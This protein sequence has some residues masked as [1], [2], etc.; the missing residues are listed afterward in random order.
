MDLSSQGKIEAAMAVLSPAQAVQLAR[1]VEMDRQR[2][3]SLPHDAILGALRP[4]LRLAVL[5]LDRLPTA[6]RLFCN[7]FE[8]LLS[9][10]PRESKMQGRIQRRAI[11]PVWRWLQDTLLKDAMPPMLARIGA[12]L[13]Q[14]GPDF[15]ETEVAALQKAAAA[16]ILEAIPSADPASP[17]FKAAAEI[18]GGPDMAADALEMARLLEVAPQI[19]SL[20]RELP[21]PVPSLDEHMLA[22]LRVSYDRL[23]ASHPGHTSYFALVVMGRLERPWEILRFAGV[24]SRKMDDVLISQTDVGAVGEILLA[25]I[26]RAAQTVAQERWGEVNAA[27][28]IAAAGSFSR[29]STGVVR[30]LGI[31]REGVWGKRIM[32]ARGQIAGAMVRLFERTE[33]VI[34]AA[35]PMQRGSSPKARRRPDVSR[36]PD[37]QKIALAD[38]LLRII[39][40]CRSFSAAGAFAS[41][42]NA[43]DELASDYLRHY[44]QELLEALREMPPEET[45]AAMRWSEPALNLSAVLLG[46]EETDLI[47]RRTLAAQAAEPDRVA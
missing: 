16:A 22:Q 11:E 47:R 5:K 14:D 6:K 19:E 34:A 20:R 46:A 18:L 3:G 7:A 44:F 13:T 29:I 12:I 27:R 15:A 10:A 17:G 24:L 35:L 28:V 23:I 36:A 1:A 25:D 45:L 39:A 40:G 8:D 43:A 4:K 31:K 21:K 33:K 26:E 2:G 42:L 9:D 38:T 37:P 41:D 32:G 30:E